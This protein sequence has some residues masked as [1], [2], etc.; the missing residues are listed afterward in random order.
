MKA[1]ILD[2]SKEEEAHPKNS[3][4]LLIRSI[5]SGK[6]KMKILKFSGSPLPFSQIQT[7]INDSNRQVES[8]RA[9]IDFI[10]DPEKKILRI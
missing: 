9:F 1:L 5:A 6:T 10:A 8:F 2:P 7:V 3:E 4:V